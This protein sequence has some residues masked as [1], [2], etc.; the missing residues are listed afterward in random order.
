MTWNELKTHKVQCTVTFVT[1]EATENAGVEI[2][3]NIG[4]RELK[5]HNFN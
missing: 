2:Y 1:Q 4:T 3:S 5:V